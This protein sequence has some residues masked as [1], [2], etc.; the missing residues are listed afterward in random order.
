MLEKEGVENSNVISNAALLNSK[1]VRQLLQRQGSLV[2][3]VMQKSTLCCDQAG[4][5][6]EQEKDLNEKSRVETKAALINS[7]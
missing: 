3:R 1:L 6:A 2:M 5:G 7:S 4:D